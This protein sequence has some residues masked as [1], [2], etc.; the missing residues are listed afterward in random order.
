MSR[1][2]RLEWLRFVVAGMRGI[3]PDH[4]MREFVCGLYKHNSLYHFDDCADQIVC[5]FS[6]EKLFTTEEAKLCNE[7][8]A[9]CYSEDMFTLATQLIEEAE[10]IP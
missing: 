5:G 1:Q 6:N 8:V 9:Y 2:Q 4:T 7:I 3:G 10:C